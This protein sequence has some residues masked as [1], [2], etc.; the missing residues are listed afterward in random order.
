[1]WASLLCP[2]QASQGS[3]RPQETKSLL[4]SFLFFF[5]FCLFRAAPAAYGGSQARGQ[6]GAVAAS[7]HHSSEQCQILNL[8]SEAREGTRVLRDTGQIRFR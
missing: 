2:T 8:L 4:L 5:F 1:M 7:L 3:G 6:I